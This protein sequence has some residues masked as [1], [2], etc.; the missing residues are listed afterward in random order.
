MKETSK[1]Y[2][3]ETVDEVDEAQLRLKLSKMGTCS[4]TEY[5][6]EVDEAQL[7]LKR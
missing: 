3:Q 6:D 1:Q 7:R 5:V 2:T 4:L